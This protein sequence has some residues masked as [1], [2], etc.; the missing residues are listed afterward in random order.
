[1]AVALALSLCANVWLLVT[2]EH[3]GGAREPTT[4]TRVPA[5]GQVKSLPGRRSA[6]TSGTE[7][8]TAKDMDDMSAHVA[9][10]ERD[11]AAAKEKASDLD[12]L[13]PV[14]MILYSTKP[15]SWKARKLLGIEPEKDRQMATWK[16]GQALGEKEGSARALIEALKVETDPKVIAI[17]GEMLRA[18]AA[19]KA[20]AEDRRAFA[21]LLRTGTTPEVRT[22][23]V[24]GVFMNEAFRGGFDDKTKALAK[25]MN[26]V[27]IDALKAE[28]SPE[29]VG[30]IAR[31]FADWSPP[32]DA[33]DALRDA[34][35]RLPASP[36]RRSVWEAIARGSFL[37]DAGVSLFTQFQ[38]ATSQDVRDDIAAG[39]ARA[40]NSMGGGAGG[41]PEEVKRRAEDARARFKVLFGGTSDVT[42]RKTLS[43]AALYGL[44]C[45]PMSLQTEEQKSDAA[46]FFR[47]VAALESDVIQRD[48]LEKIATAFETKGVE[49]F[50]V[51]DK[52]M[53]GKD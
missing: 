33:M 12:T 36:G 39:I 17:Y 42:V 50:Q 31:S 5:A 45:I 7:R 18:G 16:V 52:I 43:R 30:A 46:R 1:L 40:G 37:A 27:L 29:V 38:G 24:R 20:T 2:R 41:T 3:G 32:A 44:G 48:R 34:A 4:D 22:A 8:R 53:S 49:A 51:Y 21:E 9:E 28:S 23:S 14:A 15:L 10:L 35:A 47:E 19:S 11:L 26:G 25:E 13:D 6:D